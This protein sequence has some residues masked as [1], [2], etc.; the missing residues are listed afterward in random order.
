MEIPQKFE[1]IEKKAN[2]NKAENEYIT[3]KK[4]QDEL[5]IQKNLSV[6][7]MLPCEAYKSSLSLISDLLINIYK[8]DSFD[9]SEISDPQN[10]LLKYP[11][12]QENMRACIGEIYKLKSFLLPRSIMSKTDSFK[13]T[14]EGQSITLLYTS[15]INHIKSHQSINKF[16]ANLSPKIQMILNESNGYLQTERILSLKNKSH[17]L[18]IEMKYLYN[19]KSNNQIENIEM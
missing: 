14:I 3:N 6:L 17:H 9:I 15:D 12:I 8:N 5:K 4:Y 13:I 11:M 7:P 2:K 19:F 16:I 10:I 18:K 1:K